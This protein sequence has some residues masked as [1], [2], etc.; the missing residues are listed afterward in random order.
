MLF[1]FLSCARVPTSRRA[2][3][4]LFDRMFGYDRDYRSRSDLRVEE[5]L[6]DHLS[7]RN[8]ICE[9]EPSGDTLAVRF[10]VTGR[11]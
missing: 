5:N 11:D 10:K 7:S 9:L 2:V 1:V 8:G 6:H 3:L 4:E